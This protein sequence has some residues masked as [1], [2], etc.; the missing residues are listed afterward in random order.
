VTGA[1][2]GI[3]KSVTASIPAKVLLVDDDEQQLELRAYVL[4]KAGYSVFTAT[5][6]L[7]ALSLAPRIEG[8]DLAILD[9]EMPTM[10]GGQL[11]RQL[12]AKYPKL[13]VIL[14]SA[15]VSIPTRALDMVD[16]FIPKGENV[17]ALLQYLATVSADA[18][19]HRYHR[20][21]AAPYENSESPS[22]TR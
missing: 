3:V 2:G 11:A 1:T 18:T 13:I 21:P 19:G 8:L 4:R 17:T 12:K 9:Y 14:Y 16:A 5:G 10:N 22:A 15:A 7:Q 6:P 20:E